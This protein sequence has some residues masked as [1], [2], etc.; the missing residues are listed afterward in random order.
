MGLFREINLSSSVFLVVGNII[1]V[2]IFTTSGLIA[3]QLGSSPWVLGVWLVGGVL[4]LI[5][6]A[7]YSVLARQIPRAGGEYAYLFPVYGALPAFLSGWASLLIGF[8]APVAATALA[9]GEYLEPYLPGALAASPLRYKAVAVVT[10]L[11]V[12]VFISLGL[13]F[14]THLH[15][16]ITL[17]NLGLIV[18]FGIVVLWN[19]PAAENLGPLL[20]APASEVQLG[21][22]GS[23]LILV[24]F[25]YSGWNAAAYVAEEVR[26][27]LRNIPAALILGTVAVIGAYLLVNL[28]YFGAVPAAQLAGEIAVAQAAASAVFGALGSHFVSL[29]ILSALLSS[30]TAMAIA[31]P[32]VYFAMSRDNLCP[33]WLSHV[34]TRRHLPLRSIWFQSG[35]AVVLVTVA[36]FQQILLFSGAILVLFTTLTVSGIFQLGPGPRKL[37]PFWLFYRVLP[38]VFVV[39]NSLILISA[40]TSY[41][42]ESLAGAATLA[43]GIPV[44]LYYRHR[45]GHSRE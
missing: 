24:M 43:A 42:K 38:A 17:L 4:A 35:I 36:E 44:Y 18:G 26:H 30:L 16:A 37:Q 39:V 33:R 3:Q 19:S 6:A 9:F 21:A 12:S 15:S 29:L 45:N 13:R 23:A 27:P 1:G 25:G 28:A 31:G 2:G 5:G 20:A 11:C 41:V 7:C 32:R 8:S 40:V 10:I 22:L 14:G 34:D